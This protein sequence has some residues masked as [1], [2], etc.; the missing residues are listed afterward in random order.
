MNQGVSLLEGT[1]IYRYLLVDFYK[2][3]FSNLGFEVPDTLSN[4][5]IAYF[6]R[7]LALNIYLEEKYH[8]SVIPVNCMKLGKEDI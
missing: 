7:F 6:N 5:E 2:N 1:N 4:E 3:E 8:T